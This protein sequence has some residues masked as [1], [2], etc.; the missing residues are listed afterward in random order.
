MLKTIA[1]VINTSWNIYNFRLGLLH[2]LRDEG[3]RV[4]AIAPKDDYSAKLEQL[5]FEYHE[6]KINNKGTNPV[7]DLMLLGNL[8]RVFRKVRPDVILQYTIKPNIYGT[9]AAKLAGIPVINNI[10]GLGTV[11]LNNN[12]S[13]KLAR[14]LYRFSLGFAQKVFFQN[15]YDRQLFIDNRLVKPE[16]TD[17]LPGSGINLMKFQPAKLAKPDVLKSDAPFV[18]LLVAR[19]IKDKGIME[20]SAAAKIIL[21]DA[22]HAQK[23]EFWLL[24]DLYPGNPT[25]I[26]KQEIDKWQTDGTVKYLGHVDDVS[27]VINQANCVV[28]PS[29]REGLSRVLLEASALAKPI[30]TTDVPGC[31]DVV[32]DGVNGYLCIPKDAENLAI[33]MLKIMALPKDKLIEMGKH[34]RLKVEQQFDEKIVI[35]KYLGSIA[36]LITN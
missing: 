11:F 28:L 27:A 26:S 16:V 4:V 2:A 36:L 7:Q 15:P 30:V 20:F 19:M 21:D 23:V 29:Y 33:H 34:G 25:A 8:Y 13:S 24:G 32:D 17:L 10:S 3:Y 31:R 35:A 14:M 1:I 5:G 9:L 12:L 6:I 22:T 18:F